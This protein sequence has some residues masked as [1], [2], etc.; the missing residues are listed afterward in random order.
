MVPIIIFN[1]GETL[2]LLGIAPPSCILWRNATDVQLNF[3]LRFVFRHAFGDKI[4]GF[5]KKFAHLFLKKTLFSASYRV[6][7]GFCKLFIQ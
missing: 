4:Y 2:V 6:D 1:L 3:W 7:C 5:G